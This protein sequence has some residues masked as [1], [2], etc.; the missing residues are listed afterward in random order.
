MNNVISEIVR[1]PINWHPLGGFDQR[2]AEAIVR[3]CA[4]R[5]IS[6]SVETGAGKSTLLF[7]HLSRHH[8]VFALNEGDSLTMPLNSPLLRKEG[9]TVVEGPSQHT[10]PKHQ[11]KRLQ[12]AL[13]DG[14]HAYPFPELEYY[15]IYPH[16]DPGAV[17]IIDDIDI[18]TINNMYRI[19]RVDRMYREIAV[20][21][22][23]AF[24]ERTE[25][26]L[27]DPISGWWALQDYNKKKRVVD[28]SMSAY[29]RRAAHAIRR[30]TPAPIR[31]I[32]RTFFNQHI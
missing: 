8:T 18:P 5:D 32:G 12:L 15:Y 17:L 25:L 1:L 2:T 13:I 19:L 16:L 6:E 30:S 4:D 14:P 21:G 27:L 29:V 26:P 10:L 3:I 23:A 31:K 20:V 11:F 7:S 22:K 24:L 9:V 28:H